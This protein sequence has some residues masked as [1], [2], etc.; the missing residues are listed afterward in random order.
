MD[1]VSIADLADIVG[2][3]VTGWTPQADLVRHV[4]IHS[5]H[6]M[7]G[8]LFFALPGARTDG[9]KFARDALA[10]GAVG[11]VLA[12]GQGQGDD[13]GGP[14]IGVPD[15]LKA[16]QQ[17]AKWWRSQISATVVA[18]VG[19]SGKTVTKDALVQIRVFARD[20]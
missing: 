6:I 9:H 16:L 2:G 20:F 5:K 3:T 17:L 14:V 10:N 18:V 1:A 4:T 8:S 7:Q 19:S 11:V 12:E 15:P 13:F